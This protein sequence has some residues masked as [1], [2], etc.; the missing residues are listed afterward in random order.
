[1]L[2]IK[3]YAKLLSE[4]DATKI[5]KYF[6]KKE[7][8][9]LASAIWFFQELTN[10]KIKWIRSEEDKKILIPIAKKFSDLLKEEQMSFSDKIELVLEKTDYGLPQFSFLEAKGSRTVTCVCPKCKGYGGDGKGKPSADKAW[11]P[12]NGTAK[13]VICNHRSSCGFSGDFIAAYAEEYNLGYGAALNQLA[14]EFGI[15]FT[16]DEVH[17]EGTKEVV[18]VAPVILTPKVVERKEIVPLVF[19]PEKK[20]IKVDIEKFMSKYKDMDESQQFKMVATAIYR[21]SLETKQW[22]KETYYRDIGISVKKNPVLKEKVAMMKS[23]LGFLFT[24]DTKNLVE[25]LKDLFPTDDLIKFGVIDENE[26]FKQSVEEGLVVIP[27]FDLYTDM[28]SGLK[29]RKTKLKSWFDK[30]AGKT[31]FDNVKEPELSYGRIANPLPYHLTREALLN[32]RTS[33]RFFEG[34]KDLHSMPSKKDICDIAIPG[35]NGIS[36][37]VL[38]LFSKRAVLLYFDQDKAGQEGAMK[39]KSLLEKHGAI[40]INITWDIKFGSDVNEVLQNGKIKKI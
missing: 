33:F 17:K 3:Y 16:L 22:G 39:L 8:K 18:E 34:Q 30:K 13:S 25:H 15:D 5:N 4:E 9:S 24:T 11:I 12:V 29:F 20:F 32:K 26:K 27:N 31:V 1:M 7:F 35:V 40:V 10:E 36:E 38:G 21:F 19:N 2:D 23:K 14:S 6:S 37:E 28:C